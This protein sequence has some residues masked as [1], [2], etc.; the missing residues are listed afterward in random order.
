MYMCVYIGTKIV[1][2]VSCILHYTFYITST[3]MIII[4][5][6]IYIYIYIY[7]NC[8]YNYYR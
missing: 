6:Y 2:S 3:I 4:Y 1:I 8:K 7:I 5:T